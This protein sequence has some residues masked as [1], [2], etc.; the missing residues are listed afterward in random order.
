MRIRTSGRAHVFA[1][2]LP[3]HTCCSL[4]ILCVLWNPQACRGASATRSHCT[5]VVAAIRAHAGRELPAPYLVEALDGGHFVS[6]RDA[7][8]AERIAVKLEEEV[9][10]EAASYLAMIRAK[11]AVSAVIQNT[12]TH[13]A[14]V[15]TALAGQ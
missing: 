6:L 8:S 5:S 10:A 3:R 14:A 12:D 1:A 2:I 4:L 11:P 7:L 9:P 13:L 15:T